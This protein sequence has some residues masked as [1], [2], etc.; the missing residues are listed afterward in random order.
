M[1]K[2]NLKSGK[3]ILPSNIKPIMKAKPKFKLDPSD[4]SWSGMP[5]MK[6]REDED[7]VESILDTDVA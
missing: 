7:V 5:I 3:A 1:S 6:Y 2:P 4:E